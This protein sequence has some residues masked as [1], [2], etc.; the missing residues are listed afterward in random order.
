MALLAPT[1]DWNDVHDKHNQ[2]QELKVL[3]RKVC[4]EVFM[5]HSD[6]DEAYSNHNWALVHAAMDK[7]HTARVAIREFSRET[8]YAER[9][10]ENH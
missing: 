3:T 6:L 10:L 4:G 5:A 2:L 1:V 9:E 7:L 8:L